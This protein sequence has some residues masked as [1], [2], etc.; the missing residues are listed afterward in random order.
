MDHYG[1]SGDLYKVYKAK[2][3]EDESGGPGRPQAQRLDITSIVII[4]KKRNT[5]IP[6][7]NSLELC[8]VGFDPEK[9][10][11]SSFKGCFDL[12]EHFFAKSH[13]RIMPHSP[14]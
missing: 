9:C 8:C 1:A 14:V 5:R 10:C 3:L 2:D 4:I 6:V 13:S 11:A 7:Y 12:L